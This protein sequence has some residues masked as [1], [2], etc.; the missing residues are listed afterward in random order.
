MARYE[1]RVVPKSLKECLP[2]KSR[3]VLSVLGE[4]GWVMLLPRRTVYLS[5]NV[6]VAQY[7]T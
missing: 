6:L 4:Y 3:S 2:R 5:I 7:Y 1:A